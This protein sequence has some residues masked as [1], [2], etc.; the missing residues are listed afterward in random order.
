MNKWN[1]KQLDLFWADTHKISLDRIIWFLVTKI[2]QYDKLFDAL[3]NIDID[4]MKKELNFSLEMN[5]I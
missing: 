4:E 3:N 5:I 2:K 1:G